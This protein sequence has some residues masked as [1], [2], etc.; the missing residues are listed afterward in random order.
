MSIGPGNYC[1]EC[2]DSSTHDPCYPC[3]MKDYVELRHFTGRMIAALQAALVEAKSEV[4][5]ASCLRSL[6]DEPK[7]GV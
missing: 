3:L 1:S 6:L 7:D 2:G 4:T 5:V